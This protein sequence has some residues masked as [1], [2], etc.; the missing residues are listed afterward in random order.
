MTHNNIQEHFSFS[1]FVF[2]FV[3]QHGK[4]LIFCF[5]NLTYTEKSVLGFKK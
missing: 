5:E 2:Y 3:G 4:K 1:L